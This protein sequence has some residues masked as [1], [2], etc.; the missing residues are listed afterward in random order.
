MVRPVVFPPR[1]SSCL[2]KSVRSPLS[3]LYSI[4][5]IVP[6][7]FSHNPILS[8]ER[9]ATI[10]VIGTQRTTGEVCNTI[11]YIIPVRW[12]YSSRSRDRWMETV[13][14]PLRSTPRHASGTTTTTTFDGTHTLS[15][16]QGWPSRHTTG[17]YSITYMDPTLKYI[18]YSIE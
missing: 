3:L 2:L 17:V 5:N 4:P 13:H 7:P 11:P 8:H 15:P 9:H 18:L 12:I 14:T 1:Q 10:F 16:T 6:Y